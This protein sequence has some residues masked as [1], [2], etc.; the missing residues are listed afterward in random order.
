[1]GF[2]TGAL[3]VWLA[4]KENVWN[5]PIGIANSAFF[6]VLFWTSGLYANAGL[7]VLYIVLGFYGWW[8]WL[9]GGGDGTPLKLSRTKTTSWILLVIVTAIGTCGITVLLDHFTDST[10]P[11]WDGVT[12][13][14]S[15]TATYMLTAKLFENWWVW[16]LADLIYVPLY[17]N[18]HLYLTSAVYV[19]FLCMCIAGLVEWKRSLKGATGERSAA[20]IKGGASG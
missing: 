12:T 17:V 3:S 14:L 11:F 5:W 10:A 7:Q 9:F 20:A 2:V 1:L 16:I 8:N 18:F 15:L 6:L 19:I 4:V 13:A